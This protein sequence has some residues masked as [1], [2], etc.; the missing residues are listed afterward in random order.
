VRAGK[1]DDHPQP[2]QICVYEAALGMQAVRSAANKIRLIDIDCDRLHPAS[3]RPASAAL[4]ARVI[5]RI[6]TDTEINVVVKPVR[7]S[8]AGTHIR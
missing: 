4:A 7:L 5:I 3:I 2:T 6:C 8:I 1:P